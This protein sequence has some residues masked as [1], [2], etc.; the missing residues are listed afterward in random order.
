MHFWRWAGQQSFASGL[1]FNVLGYG[2]NGASTPAGWEIEVGTLEETFEVSTLVSGVCNT[3][4]TE[5]QTFFCTYQI[6]SAAHGQV[7][8]R[9]VAKFTPAES[10]RITITVSP[11]SP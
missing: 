10:G 3:T 8:L 7:Y 4:V 1:T 2:A 6:P 5:G 11:G 9:A